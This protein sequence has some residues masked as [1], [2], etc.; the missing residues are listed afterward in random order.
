MLAVFEV[1]GAPEAHISDDGCTIFGSVHPMFL[2]EKVFLIHR[3]TGKSYRVN[4]CEIF[5]PAERR[6]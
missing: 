4:G 3:G 5:V 6:K 1:K 2:R